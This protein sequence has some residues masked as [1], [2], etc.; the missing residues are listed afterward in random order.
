MRFT[1]H[2]YT[3]STMQCVGQL[4]GFIKKYLSERKWREDLGKDITESYLVATGCC[5]K[6]ELIIS[7]WLDLPADHVCPQ[8]VCGP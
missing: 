5:K 2:A 7:T 1:L 3:V 4:L 8:G 6:K